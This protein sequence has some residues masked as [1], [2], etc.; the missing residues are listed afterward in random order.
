MTPENIKECL[1]TV[2]GLSKRTCPCD[3]A[4]K[5]ANAGDSRSGYFL[6]DAADGVP[7]SFIGGAVD[8]ANGGTWDIL[9]DSRDE[10]IADF[11][12]DMSLQ[13][14]DLW[15]KSF[16]D[17]NGRIGEVNDTTYVTNAKRFAVIRIRGFRGV[18][19]K[20]KLLA[21]SLKATCSS[22]V[23]IDIFDN[24][25]LSGIPLHSVTVNTVAQSWQ[26]ATWATAPQLDLKNDYGDYQDYYLVYQIPVGCYMANSTNGCFSCS[27]GT[28]RGW[29]PFIEVD[30][31][32]VDNLTDFA[33]MSATLVTSHGQLTLGLSLHAYIGCNFGDWLCNLDFTLADNGFQLTVAKMLQYAQVMKLVTVLVNSP[34]FNSITLL[35]KENLYG[36]RAHA[37]KEY[38]NGIRW[39]A[40][41]LPQ[42]ALR[43]YECKDRRMAI[44]ALIV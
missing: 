21:A 20:L 41:N 38:A 19:A 26:S 34:N 44:K 14:S 10:G 9:A 28:Q 39:I 36:R 5:P 33:G 6:T 2:V 17:F 11:I 3:G 23:T 13:M 40:E 1:K 43:C 37:Q 18:P 30:S 4:G 42:D 15:K 12:R 7:M 24:T 31:F 27:G 25:S 16:E 8:C 29:Q 32:S 22:P 35:S